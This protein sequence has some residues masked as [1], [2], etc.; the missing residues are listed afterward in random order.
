MAA[1]TWCQDVW[2]VRSDPCGLFSAFFTMVL[3]LYAQLVIV[4]VL[5]LPWYGGMCSHVYLYTC[6]SVLAA[7][8]HCRYYYC[9]YCCY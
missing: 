9:Y 6:C 4:F 8:S 1:K 5:L 7:F 3:L 2:W